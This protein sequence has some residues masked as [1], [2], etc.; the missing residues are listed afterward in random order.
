MNAPVALKQIE[1]QPCR[2]AA[3]AGQAA[4]AVHQQAGVIVGQRQ[5]FLDLFKAGNTERGVARL[6][7]AQQFAAAAQSPA[8]AEAAG[9]WIK[10]VDQEIA[11]RE[12]VRAM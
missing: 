11:R 8:L 4:V 9:N 3:F 7:G 6:A 10:F 2:C 1:Q 5:Q 12:A